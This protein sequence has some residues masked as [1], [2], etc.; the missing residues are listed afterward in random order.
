LKSKNYLKLILIGLICLLFFAGTN[1][2]QKNSVHTLINSY[3]DSKALDISQIFFPLTNTGNINWR[4]DDYQ[5]VTWEQIADYNT[6]VFDQGL[7]VLGKID[8]VPH[9][10]YGKWSSVY[11][12]GPI[13]DGQAAMLI[14][15]EDSSR[16]RV[17]KIS[18]GDDDSNPDYLEWPV[19]FGA[20]VNAMGEPRIYA[21]QTL[22][23]VYNGLDST[24]DGRSNHFDTMAV[25][26]VEVNQTVYAHEGLV[27]D[28][29]NIFSNISFLEYQVINKGVENID[30]TYIGFWTDIDFYDAS[31]NPPGIDTLNQLGYCWYNKDS[32]A[33]NPGITPPAVGYVQLY[34]PTVPSAGS[35]AI[36]KGKR[37]ENFKNLSLSTFHGIRDDAWLAPLDGNPFTLNHSWNVARGLDMTGNVIVDPTTGQPTKF[38]FSGDPVTNTGWIWENGT[39]G[40]AGFVIF[41]GPF[42]MAP[43]DTQWVMFALVPGL[44]TDPFQSIEAMRKK[45]SII[46]QMPYDSL[47]AGK[48]AIGIWYAGEARVALDKISVQ[49]DVDSLILQATFPNPDEHDFTAQAIVNSIDNT[50]TDSVF[51]YDDG[52]HHDLEADDGIWGT[53]IPPVAQENTF[54]VSLIAND[55]ISKAH[56]ASNELAG[57]TSI[58]PVSLNKYTIISPDTIPNPGDQIN[59]ELIL[60]NEGLVT[61]ATNISTV[62][63]SLDTCATLAISFE[64]PIYGDIA[65]GQS[66]SGSRGHRVNFSKSCPDSIWISFEVEIY[67][68][69]HLF[70]TDTLAVFIH[71]T[72]STITDFK[73]DLPERFALK[74][75]YP[76]P[77]NPR[78]IINY[79][80]PITNYVE[81]SVFNLI[82]QKVVTLVSEKQAAGYHQVEWDAS[83]LSS[84]IYYYM[85]KV[86]E[87][88]DIKKMVLIR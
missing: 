36:Y 11:S 70:W 27:S 48:R 2:K 85:I 65:A 41:S 3:H 55:L 54:N 16:Y 69:D 38:P 20:P 56:F 77:F 31:W 14:N 87:F 23:T 37:R 73:T 22:W 19:E 59:F 29:E 62:L 72:P 67:S 86:G 18:K 79:E 15:P 45:V 63:N 51:I 61:D 66:T 84:G 40:G 60:K 5:S 76:N 75:N 53:I 6:I 39:D 24:T 44:G 8:D 7:W 43:G 4:S 57:F 64:D 88:Q 34:G 80:L 78:T 83:G 68:H 82:G 52:N 49:A 10:S 50:F 81:L 35:T 42:T 9:W 71:G 21:D 17:Y 28:A 30:S 58:G 33:W 12:P 1:L 25:M 46:S 26:P 74:Q 13:I 32:S 47:V